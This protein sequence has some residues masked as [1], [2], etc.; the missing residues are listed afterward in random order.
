M[1]NK[2]GP[3]GT[4]PAVVNVAPEGGP[5]QHQLGQSVGVGAQAGDAS[6]GAKE[7]A[8]NS[9]ALDGMPCSFFL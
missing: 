2:S 1:L 5:E 4:E 9:A 8:P 7:H 6:A 3:P